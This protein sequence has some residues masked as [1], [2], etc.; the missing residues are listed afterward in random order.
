MNK[1]VFHEGRW[2]EVRGCGTGAVERKPR[3][4]KV[5]V[6]PTREGEDQ[7]TGYRNSAVVSEER[8][9]VVTGCGVREETPTGR[10]VAVSPIPS[11]PETREQSPAGYLEGVVAGE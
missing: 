5:A 10:K 11:N 3:Y 7:A 4:R 9:Q 6:S 1:V 8:L 2:R